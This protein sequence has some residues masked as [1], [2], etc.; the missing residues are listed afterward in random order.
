[1]K[2]NKIV[3]TSSATRIKKTL[4][5]TTALGFFLQQLVPYSLAF[6]VG[7]EEKED[8][9]KS[10]RLRNS[11]QESSQLRETLTSDGETPLYFAALYG[12]KD[13]A[14]FFIKNGAKTVCTIRESSG[15]SVVVDIVKEYLQ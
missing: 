13:L 12:H 5:V 1:M 7:G 14:R 4:H 10:V 15:K 3:Q 11:N 9:Y 6:A 2:E 8:K